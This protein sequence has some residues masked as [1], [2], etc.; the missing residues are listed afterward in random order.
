MPKKDSDLE[1]GDRGGVDVA[2]GEQDPVVL[3][4]RLVA[5]AGRDRCWLLAED[6]EADE[7]RRV[8]AMCLCSRE[9]RAGRLAGPYTPELAG[10]WAGILLSEDL[11]LD[12]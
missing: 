1:L 6:L 9:I 8:A 10:R 2:V 4:G 3:E 12:G 7:L 5:I 11:G